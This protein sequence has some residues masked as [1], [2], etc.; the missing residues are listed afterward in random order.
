[1]DPLVAVLDS[2][3][4][5]T[6][7]VITITLGYS[8]RVADRGLVA[9]LSVDAGAR[10]RQWRQNVPPRADRAVYGGICLTLFLSLVGTVLG[11]IWA[12]YSWGA[13]GAG[14]RRKTA[15]C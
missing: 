7:H 12:N 3:F 11:G 6:V 10:A 13:S 8:R 14:T 5:L 4:W 2:N 15:R 9:R 1:M